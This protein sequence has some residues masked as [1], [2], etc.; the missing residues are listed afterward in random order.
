MV[1]SHG[2]TRVA[3]TASSTLQEADYWHGNKKDEEC[4]SMHQAEVILKNEVRYSRWIHT[5]A[6]GLVNHLHVDLLLLNGSDL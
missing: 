4:E 6:A 5:A 1:P 2:A 3:Q